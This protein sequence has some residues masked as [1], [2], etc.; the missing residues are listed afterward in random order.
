MQIIY[1]LGDPATGEVRYVGITN[2]LK[3]RRRNHLNCFD[4]TYRSCWIRSLKDRG[5]E[6]VFTVLEEVPDHTLAAQAE[7]AWIERLVKEGARLVN[8]TKGG[9]GAPGIDFKEASLALMRS[10][11]L[12]P[13]NPN[14]KLSAHQRRQIIEMH[15]DGYHSG[16][17]SRFVGVSLGQIGRVLRGA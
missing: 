6:P 10:K 2:N 17:I 12:G 4:R 11:K 16:Q 14:Y 9:D 15:L 5:D 3:R 1:S 13:G 7:R 8:L